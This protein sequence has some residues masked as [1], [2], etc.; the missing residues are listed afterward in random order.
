M[1]VIQRIKRILSAGP[2]E[3]IAFGLSGALIAI[4][5]VAMF[6]GTRSELERMAFE[7]SQLEEREQ[8]MEDVKITTTVAD[9]Q[10]NYTIESIKLTQ[11]PER[12]LSKFVS[13]VVTERRPDGSE[14]IISA[15]IGTMVQGENTFE[16]EG[17]VEIVEK[18]TT[19]DTETSIVNA[20]KLTI[21]LE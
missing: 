14:R 4:C 9:L 18:S 19:D 5:V 3:L 21:N 1:N 7:G 15:P 17:G 13:P 6:G 11:Y 20:S 12:G 2:L 16:L 10:V 8:I